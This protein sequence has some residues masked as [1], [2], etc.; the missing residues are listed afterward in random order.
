MGIAKSSKRPVSG[1]RQSPAHKGVE[2]HWACGR[3]RT[4][5]CVMLTWVINVVCM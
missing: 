4:C 1:K 5:A 3:M 2:P